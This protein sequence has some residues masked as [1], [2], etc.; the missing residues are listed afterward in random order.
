VSHHGGCVAW[1]RRSHGMT[2]VSLRWCGMAAMVTPRQSE[3]A[4]PTVEC[5]A[6]RHVRWR[7]HG[8]GARVVGKGHGKA[9]SAAGE[10]YDEVARAVGAAGTRKVASGGTREGYFF[11]A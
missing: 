2:V 5:T 9:A 10:R 4:P 6:T 7:G 3:V 8:Q 11:Q 1:Q